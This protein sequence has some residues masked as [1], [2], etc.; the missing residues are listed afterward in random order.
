MQFILFIFE[1]VYTATR[2]TAL[3][4]IKRNEKK[5]KN[6]Y[7]NENDSNENEKNKIKK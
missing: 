7:I 2:S 1:M 5:I 4:Y 3:M 6:L